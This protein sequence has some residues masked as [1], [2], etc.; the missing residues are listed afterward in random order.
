[1]HQSVFVYNRLDSIDTHFY[2]FSSS[3]QTFPDLSRQKFWKIFDSIFSPILAES[4][5]L[6]GFCQR[7]PRLDLYSFLSFFSS[8]QT[9]PDL[10]RQKFKKN[11]SSTFSPILGEFNAPIGFC[12]RPPSL[13]L[14]SFLSFFQL[15]PDL[16]RRFQTFPDLSRQKFWRHF[17][18]ILSPILGEFNAP[19]GFCLRPPRLDL[20][21]FLSFF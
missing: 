13:D 4:N 14:Y 11:F 7:P 2:H 6:I 19:I 16:F 20:Y 12:L 1:M 17:C 5:A 9:F 10:S 3:F 21:S 15:F 18:S 8:F